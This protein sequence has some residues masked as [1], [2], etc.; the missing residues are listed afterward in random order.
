MAGQVRI[1]F[2]V[3]SQRGL[4]EFDKLN[5][6]Q[7]RTIVLGSKIGKEFDKTGKKIQKTGKKG[8]DAFAGFK[9]KLVASV[10]VANVLSRAIGLVN[11]RLEKQINLNN[12][13]NEK[14]Q[15]FEA[16]TGNFI[17]NNQQA[18]QRNPNLLKQ[19]R[20]FSRTQG[21]RLGAG[22]AAEVLQ[23]LTDVR[24]QAGEGFTLK[25][26]LGAVQKAVQGKVLDPSA[27]IG[28]IASAN[29]RVQK[30]LGVSERQAQNALIAF[31]PTAGGDVNAF[32][33]EFGKLAGLTGATRQIEKRQ[34]G[35]S[36]TEL[37]D[38]LALEGVSSQALGLSPEETTTIIQSVVSKVGSARFGKKDLKFKSENAVDRILELSERVLSGEFGTGAERQ[39]VLTSAGLKGAK[40]LSFLGALAEARPQLA[41]GRKSISGAITSGADIQ[42]ESLKLL[43]PQ[44]NLFRST[45]GIVGGVESQ[46][47]ADTELQRRTEGAKQARAILESKGDTG[48]GGDALVGA[49]KLGV[50]DES[51][52]VSASESP[53]QSILDIFFTRTKEQI[54]SQEKLNELMKEA[55]IE[56]KKTNQN[57]DLLFKRLVEKELSTPPGEGQ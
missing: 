55:G 17:A 23:A 40:G 36:K 35:A 6:K 25:Q 53:I 1:E 48:L 43:S 8:V 4:A 32:V 22:G 27:D 15:T 2:D 16:A 24:S 51:L 30:S 20:Q 45:R 54:D 3:Q 29:L 11:S 47:L 37:A 12:R 28:A 14:Q 52:S 7:Q 34:F 26:Q 41:G 10:D 5:K 39:Q 42:S 46:Q 33:G 31:G 57:F 56:A 18:I 44:A 13:I 38:I 9:N 21:S 50:F 49:K 19:A